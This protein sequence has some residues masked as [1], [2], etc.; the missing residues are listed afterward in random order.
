MKLNFTPGIIKLKDIK[1]KGFIN[2]LNNL[3]HKYGA[4]LFANGFMY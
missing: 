4:A 2:S 3:P 1:Y